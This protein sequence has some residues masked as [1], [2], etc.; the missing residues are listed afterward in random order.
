MRGC[1][2]LGIIACPGSWMPCLVPNFHT[3]RVVNWKACF[4]GFRHFFSCKFLVVYVSRTKRANCPNTTRRAPCG[5]KPYIRGG[6]ARCPEGIVCDTA[7]TTSVPCSLHYD[8]SHLGFDGPE[9]F[10]ASQ[11]VT[12][13][14]DE[15]AYGW[16]LE[17]CIA[18]CQTAWFVKLEDKEII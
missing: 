4:E 18:T 17:D 10:F 3:N 1:F 11:D 13:V 8:D 9:P 6:A 2:S 16:I 12:S 5:W 14:R 15:V 7:V